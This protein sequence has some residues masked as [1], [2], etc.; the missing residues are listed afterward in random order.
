VPGIDFDAL[1]PAQLRQ[2]ERVLRGVPDRFIDWCARVSPSYRWDWPHLVRLTNELQRLA[3]GENDRLI[4]QIPVRHGKSETATI[5][6]P[7]WWLLSQ[8][9]DRAIIGAYN[10]T[11]AA[12]FSRKARRIARHAGLHV[13]DERS[14]V[15]DWETLEGGGMRAVGVGGGITG[16]GGNLIAVDD[17]V[18]SREEAES[19]VYRER[20][21]EWWTS[22][23]WTRREPGAAVVLTMSRWHEDDLAGRILNGPD[24]DEWTLLSLPALAEADDPLGRAE[25]QAL[26]PDRFDEE[27]LKATRLVIGDYAFSALYQQ[28]P[29]PREGRMFPRE[30]VQI[31][32]AVPAE[33]RM[34][35]C[36]D[37]AGSE[38][39]GDWT[40]GVKLS[41]H[42][43]IYY[44]EDVDRCRREALL[45][46]Q[47]M[48]ITAE[49]DGT[50]CPVHIEQE[51]GSGG[52][53]SAAD[54]IRMLAGFAVTAA[55]VTGDKVVRAMPFAA[56]WQAGNVRILRGDWNR[57]YLDEMERFPHGAH[58]D[59]VDGS[60]G[61]FNRLANRPAS[62]RASV[63]D[64]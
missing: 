56:Q 9:T 1:T 8:P 62:P 18:K 32:D 13:S 44:I 41:E 43:G 16:Q 35:R 15:E 36:W 31:V 21:W 39:S 48:R 55:P 54:D 11:L 2:A 30:L 52:K 6:F 29:T 51:P 45:R 63:V 19:P 26:C 24:G 46:R 60:S 22:D 28:N 27:A 34:L 53:D 42:G 20:V 12:K 25:G 23:L 37:K 10:A 50:N 49:L 59:Q 4:I 58:D 33:R 3:D 40:A 14:A 64:W 7:V 38:A 57:E 17:P 5:R 61:A 47:R